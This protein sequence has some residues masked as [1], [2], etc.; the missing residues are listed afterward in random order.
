M[1]VYTVKWCQFAGNIGAA[2][3]FVCKLNCKNGLA[4]VTG[5]TNLPPPSAGIFDPPYAINVNL[6]QVPV[7]TKV[8]YPSNSAPAALGPDTKIN[9]RITPLTKE[10]LHNAGLWSFME[11]MGV[12]NGG[13]LQVWH[14]CS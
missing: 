12:K 11:Q 8:T 2:T 4:E 9:L 6:T 1:R 5:L 7:G 3:D 14:L 10:Y 13:L